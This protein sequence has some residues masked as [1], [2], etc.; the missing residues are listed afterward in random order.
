MAIAVVA[1]A[2]SFG[3]EPAAPLFAVEQPAQTLA[4]ALRAIA[5]QAGVSIVF[6]PV[7]AAGRMAK[8][9]RGR[10]TAADAVA[11]ALEGTG[12]V[13]QS[14]PDGSLV[15][16][17][18]SAT[19]PS[20]AGSGA[21]TTELEKVDI[22]GTRLTRI[23]REG[24]APVHTYTREDI[25]RSGQPTLE[26]FLSSL[27]E[28]SMA[29]GEGAFSITLGQGTVQLRGL[30]L[31]STLVLI[32]G[33]RVEAVGSSSADFFNLNLIPTAAIERV[34]IVPVGSSA[35]YGG[36]ALAGVVNVILKRSLDGTSLSA[37]LGSGKGFG[38]GSFSLA[39]GGT[40]GDGTYLLLGSYRRQT[41][42]YMG[43]RGFFRD[44]DYRRFG[45]T[46][47]RS[48]SCTPGTVSSSDG[49]NLPGLTSSFAGIPSNRS[50]AAL[51]PSDFASGAGQANLCGPYTN[52]NGYALAQGEET[53]GLHAPRR[54]AARRQLDTVRR[55][56]AGAGSSLRRRDGALGP[57]RSRGRRATPTTRSANR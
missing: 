48:R 55:G 25:E 56:D 6:D 36:D 34:D 27:N 38:D 11:Q 21:R 14:M 8:A 42:L 22:T 18:G 54:P 24:P 5:R 16:K 32:N 23:D 19:A 50:G 9:V 52:G 17:A 1:S 47:A 13:V 7:I 26:R 44:A 28:V 51:Q 43:E 15:V 37:G 2:G 46:D 39:H 29:Q 4:D 40:V 12:L 41:P 33:R 3:S 49:S 30:P 53:V 35:V 45:G 20:P 10:L 57:R 31:G